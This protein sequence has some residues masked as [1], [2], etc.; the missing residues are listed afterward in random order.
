MSIRLL[1][2]D[3][4]EVLATLDA[5]SI[6]ACVTDPPY[7]LGSMV[8]RLSR[9]N[10]A[11]V[12]KNFSKTVEGQ[13]RSPYAALAVG[14]MGKTW[15]GGDVAMRA[16]TWAEVARV[17]KPGAH[18][19]AFGGTRTFHRVAVAIEDAGFEIRD[20]LCWLYG[21]GFPKS[22]N[23]PGGW[24]TALKPAW[25]PIILA[26]KPLDG[27]VAANMAAHGTG[28]LNIDAT[29]VS[30]D[31]ANDPNK[32]GLGY[33]FTKQGYDKKAAFAN[34]E[35][36]TGYDTTKGRWPANVAHDGSDEVLD[37]FARFG[38]KASGSGAV[39]RASSADRSGNRG[40]AYGAESRP[41]GTAM[42][43]HADTGSAA[44]FFYEA[45]A[46]REERGEGNN[47]PTVKPLALMRWLCRLVTPPGGTVLDPFLGSGSTALAADQEGFHCIGI[48]QSAEY[49]EIARRR[50]ATEAPLF[51]EVA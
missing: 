2:G 38:E 22:H 12:A 7:H 40:A 29:R 39:K 16:E 43:S 30:A 24:G 45:K 14:F 1:Q 10:A 19:A 23:Q 48:E 8:K 21:S 17:L 41:A 9:T 32:R 15:D 18:L 20:T 37:A 33:G 25:E 5:G 35:E 6:D 44:R 51:T 50:L 31:W 46:S 11:D 28:A 13:A 34:S 49:L 3:C 26:R 36:R 27:T 47:H 4:R 42:I